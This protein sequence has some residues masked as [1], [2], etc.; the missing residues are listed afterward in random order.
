MLLSLLVMHLGTVSLSNVS[1]TQYQGID[2][3]CLFGVVFSVEKKNMWIMTPAVGSSSY[4]HSMIGYHFLETKDVEMN[5]AHQGSA[6]V[7]RDG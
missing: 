6:Q 3:F 2:F 4:V 1:L 5:E 7:L